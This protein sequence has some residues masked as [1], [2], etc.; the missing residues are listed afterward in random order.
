[1]DGKSLS[2]D[3]QFHP[4]SYWD[5]EDLQGTED[6]GKEAGSRARYIVTRQPGEEVTIGM[7]YHGLSPPVR[8]MSR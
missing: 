6:N 4:K 7:I 5:E 8:V 1:M 3:L 2:I